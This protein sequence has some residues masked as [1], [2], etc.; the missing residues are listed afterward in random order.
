MSSERSAVKPSECENVTKKAKRSKILKQGLH[1][2]S[3]ISALRH[4]KKKD[5]CRGRTLAL[6]ETF[7]LGFNNFY[8]CTMHLD[9]VKFFFTNKYT[10]Y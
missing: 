6:I 4:C 2:R 3:E 10:F 7:S 9:N 5:H 8:R 1:Q